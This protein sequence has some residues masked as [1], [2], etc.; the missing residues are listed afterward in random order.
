MRNTSTLRGGRYLVQNPLLLGWLRVSDLF[1]DVI[2]ARPAAPV[3]ASRVRAVLLAVGGHIGDAIIATALLAPVQRAFPSA[4]IGVL[5]A[6]WTR[7]IF[8]RHPRVARV[9]VRDHW[10][11]ERGL[12][13]WGRKMGASFATSR[14]ARRE[15]AAEAYDLAIDLSPY[16]PNAAMLL[17]RSGIPVRVGFTSGGRGKLFSHPVDWIPGRHASEDHLFLLRQVAPAMA[18]TSVRYELPP[19]HGEMPVALADASGRYV[20]LH[21]GAGHPLKEWPPEHWVEVARAVDAAGLRV[22]LTGAGVRQAAMARELAVR[23]PA[24][25]LC[26]ALDWNGFRAVV[27]GARAVL[28]VDTVAGH[29]AAAVGTPSVVV[30]AV[31]DDARRWRPLGDRVAVVPYRVY[32]EAPE[33]PVTPSAVLD[34]ASGFLP[35]LAATRRS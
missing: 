3:D 25:N 6:S 19:A 7:H 24:V 20:V 30:M 23:A 21:M 33:P 4:R 29:L 11:H 15:I 16:W 28:T 1:L 2:R 34:A 35:E 31:L 13:S 8:E 18:G 32:S 27:E 17:W 10:R 22:V 12:R 9:H 5:T 14:R 26:D